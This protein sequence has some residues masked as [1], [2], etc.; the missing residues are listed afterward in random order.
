MADITSGSTSETL[1]PTTPAEGVRTTTF[2]QDTA[3]QKYWPE[4]VLRIAFAEAAWP[5]VLLIADAVW[6][7]IS[8]G[9]YSFQAGVILART[10]VALVGG[11]LS[12]VVTAVLACIVAGAGDFL[13]KRLHFDVENVPT[14]ILAGG[15]VGLLLTLSFGPW[16][17]EL[18][19]ISLW[20][21]GTATTLGQVGGC[22]GAWSALRFGRQSLEVDYPQSQSF[23]FNLGQ[24]LQVTA[25]F[26]VV[27]TILKICGMLSPSF[28][29][30]F[31]G[32]T[33]LQVGALGVYLLF[34]RLR[35]KPLRRST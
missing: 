33:A 11:G 27:L 32:W 1:I 10:F 28:L 17:G 12:F 23:Q 7:Q 4:V 3:F 15:T 24:V 18:V 16:L 35:A 20:L 8:I 5:T 29:A 25:I 21:M 26:A 34:C 2:V 22:W 13:G 19:P 6:K 14:A 31:G 30:F 9:S